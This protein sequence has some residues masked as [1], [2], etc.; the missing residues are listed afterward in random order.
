MDSKLQR[1]GQ[2]QTI[3]FKK[4]VSGKSSAVSQSETWLVGRYKDSNAC[5]SH[6]L[7]PTDLTGNI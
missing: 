2:T 6:T 7:R 3:N 4:R 1:F 5:L